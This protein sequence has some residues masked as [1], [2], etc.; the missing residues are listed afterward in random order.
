MIYAGAKSRL[1]FCPQLMTAHSFCISPSTPA[2][3]IRPL[4][5]VRSDVPRPSGALV[6]V[7]GPPAQSL[8]VI[9]EAV[10]TAFRDV[11]VCIVPSAGVLT[12]RGGLES[13]SAVGGVLWSGGH[14]AVLRLPDSAPKEALAETLESAVG[15]RSATV[16]LF[17]RSDF[18]SDALAMVS[19]RAPH[20]CLLGAGTVGG[21][22]IAQDASGDN[23]SGSAVGLILHGGAPPLVD[24][25]GACRL[26][27]SFRRIE[28]VGDN[29]V[30]RVEG[31]SA[32]EFLSSCA[33]GLPRP[34]AAGTQPL[35]LAALS[36]S[37]ESD[38]YVLRPVRG[39]SPGR[40]GIMIGPDARPG[41]RL[42][43][44]VRD[45]KVARTELETMARRVSRKAL[46]A[47][48]Q[49]ALF[50]SCAGRGRGLYGAPD[51]EPRMLRKCF[52][53]LPIAGMLSAFEISPRAPGNSEIA[54]YTGVLALF[55]RPS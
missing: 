24:S 43:F 48:P 20:V 45:G 33:E 31:S 55:R 5:A 36:E 4:S 32:L 52:P 9:A 49:F 41:M 21:A 12:E 23:H 3:L 44:A 1:R 18:S 16:L 40:G 51:V 19:K 30:L 50:L 47:A 26:V 39:L 6:F 17:P 28:E 29:L 25:A 10:H 14:A 8:G 13:S 35:V 15:E 7:S 37:A 46:G 38:A 54:L 11:P 2:E 53:D 22:A 42:A 34:G 27:S